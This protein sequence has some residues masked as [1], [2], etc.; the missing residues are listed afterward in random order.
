MFGATLYSASHTRFHISSFFTLHLVTKLFFHNIPI[1]LN[2]IHVGKFRGHSRRGVSLHSRN[3]L[4]LLELWHGAKSCI[5]I[6]HFFGNTTHSHSS[7]FRCHNNRCYCRVWRKQT[8][9][10]HAKCIQT[11]VKSPVSVQLWGAVSRREKL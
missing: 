5:K 3:V 6:Y 11:T 8:E 1:V 9:K 10:H 4:V 7:V 2:G